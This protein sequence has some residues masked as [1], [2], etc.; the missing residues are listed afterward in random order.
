MV[1]IKKDKDLSSI[2]DICN[3]ELV[4]KS[5]ELFYEF[6]RIKYPL[7]DVNCAGTILE[8]CIFNTLKQKLKSLKKNKKQS[9]PDFWNNSFE[10][11]IKTFIKSPSFDISNFQSLINQLSEENGVYKKLFNTKFL[12]FEYSI[13]D[14]I[15]KIKKF[16]CLN[17]WNLFNYQGKYPLSL[18]CK[19]GIWYNL[20]PSTSTKWSD[21]D[22]TWKLFIEN[23]YKCIEI[24]PNIIINKEE[25]INSILKQYIKLKNTF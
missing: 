18:Q 13:K 22:K 21:K 7:C 1:I 8:N 23:I 10:Y 16:W 3:K 17:I 2:I 15:V 19:K 4:N 5:I 9:S 25:K 6:N 11:E 14:N 12:I 24:C 20:R